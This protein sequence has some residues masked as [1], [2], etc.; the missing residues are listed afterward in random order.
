MAVLKA[1][2]IGFGR[3][4]DRI[5]TYRAIAG[6]GFQSLSGRCV[7]CQISAVAV[8]ETIGGIFAGIAD[9]VR[10]TATLAVGTIIRVLPLARFALAV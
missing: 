7:A 8:R 9:P 5:P 6:T 4:A 1:G 3:F 2:K 10:L